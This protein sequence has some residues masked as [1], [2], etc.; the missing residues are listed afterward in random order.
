MEK[1]AFSEQLDRHVRDRPSNLLQLK[2]ACVG[3]GFSETLQKRRRHRRGS[4]YDRHDPANLG[5]TSRKTG[6]DL[7][8]AAGPG[9]LRRV[10]ATSDDLDTVIFYGGKQF[11]M[12]ARMCA[13]RAPF[14]GILAGG[15]RW[16]HFNS[17]F[18]L[19]P[20]WIR[21][22]ERERPKRCEKRTAF[23]AKLTQ[24]S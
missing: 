9:S 5:V 18:S 21:R 20:F 14:I 16:L 11:R 19:L 13:A 2:L 10:G 1:F 24:G 17:I 8:I 22:C 23:G 7:C 12:K 6:N 4:A 15:L 3:L